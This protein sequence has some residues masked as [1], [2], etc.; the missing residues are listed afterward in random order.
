MFTLKWKIL[1]TYKKPKAQQQSN[2]SSAKGG[3]GI[4]HNMIKCCGR[5]E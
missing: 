2:Q 3:G 4:L 5:T 1:E